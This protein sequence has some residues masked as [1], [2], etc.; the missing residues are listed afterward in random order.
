MAAWASGPG[1]IVLSTFLQLAPKF[2]VMNAL[3]V[4]GRADAELLMRKNLAAALVV[5]LGGEMVWTAFRPRG[6]PL[7]WAGALLLLSTSTGALH[8]ALAYAGPQL[9]GPHSAFWLQAVAGCLTI[10]VN[11]CTALWR[12]GQSRSPAK[13]RM[14]GW[15]LSVGLG[16]IALLLRTAATATPTLI[17]YSAFPLLVGLA[18]CKSGETARTADGRDG[19]GG[20]ASSTKGQ[21][22]SICV[23]VGTALHYV[24]LAVVLGTNAEA[25]NDVAVGLR[26][27][28]SLSQGSTELALT[29]NGSVLLSQL[30]AL[31]SDQGLARGSERVRSLAFL[32]VWSTCQLLRGLLMARLDSGGASAQGLLAVFVFLDK[33]TG[34]LGQAALDTAAVAVLQSHPLPDDNDTGGLS[35]GRH[36]GS[37]RRRSWLLA[38]PAPF[39]ISLRA[40]S[41]KYERPLW[42]MLLLREAEWP[43][44]FTAVVLA[45]VIAV[46]AGVVHALLAYVREQEP[47]SKRA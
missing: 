1:L 45:L 46:T 38:V 7:R 22:S 26:V 6:V 18:L 8:T 25:I 40:A 11:Q 42:E 9:Y 3:L 20:A 10:P 28:T 44:T 12:L 39:L 31:L 36:R 29:N 27:R 2:L 13:W 17:L 21:S 19:G 43:V 33:Y 15:I 41:F 35:R 34:P 23:S 14:V 32:G 16:T 5:S 47:K 30:L 4:D 24:L 37:D